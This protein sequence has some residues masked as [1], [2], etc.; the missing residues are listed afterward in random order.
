MQDI[1]TKIYEMTAIGAIIDSPQFLI[2]YA[3]AFLLLYLGIKKEF[4]PL[5]LVPIAFGVLI[6]NFPNGGMGV[7]AADGE[8]LVHYM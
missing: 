5:L 6:A 7:L 3:L 2:M 1:I 8:G 4:E